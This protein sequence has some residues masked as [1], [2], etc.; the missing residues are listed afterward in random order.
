VIPPA[1]TGRE[2]KSKKTVTTIAQRKIAKCSKAAGPFALRIVTKKFTLPIKE[3]IPARC[4]EKIVKST[5]A[6]L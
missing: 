1:K 6:P 3:E 5:L 2:S 4:K